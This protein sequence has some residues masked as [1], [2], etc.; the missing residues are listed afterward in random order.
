LPTIIVVIFVIAYA[1]IA[2]EHP[3]KI[4]KGASALLGAGLLWTIYATFSSDH[5]IVGQQ[6]NESVTSTAQIVL[7]L[8]G[9]MTI[10]EGIDARRTRNPQDA[11]FGETTDRRDRVPGFRFRNSDRRL[12]LSNDLLQVPPPPPLLLPAFRARAD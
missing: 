6:L 8:I 12:R 10:V 5:A 11:V 2:L 4:N 1:A 7:F 3:I 9:A